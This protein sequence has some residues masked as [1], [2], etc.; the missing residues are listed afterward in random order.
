MA[1][2]YAFQA[3]SI[4]T[5]VLEGGK[6]VDMVGASALVDA[7]ARDDGAD[8]VAAMLAA[9][10]ADPANTG[11]DF[12]FTFT[13]RAG[14]A[15]TFTSEDA[16]AA[17][18]F[19]AA[20]T[21]RFASRFEGLPFVDALVAGAPG[22]PAE[23]LQAAVEPVLGAERSRPPPVPVVTAFAARTAPRTGRVAVALDRRRGKEPID[24]PTR[25]K[26]QAARAVLE[27]DVLARR[28]LG[29]EA[30]AACVFPI[31][32]DADAEDGRR[33]PFDGDLKTVAIVH[34]DGNALGGKII[35]LLG[36]GRDFGKGETLKA[37]S[38][39]VA[40]ATEEAVQQAFA[41]A[42]PAALRPEVTLGDGTRRAMVPARP[43][44]VGGDDVTMILR[45]DVALGW[46]AAFLTAFRA[47]SVTAFGAAAEDLRTRGRTTEAGVLTELFGAGLSAGAGIAYAS[48]SMPFDQLYGLCED[49]AKHAKVQA[50]AVAGEEGAA[51]PPSY[52]S[53][54]RTTASAMEGYGELLGGALRAA[55]GRLLTLNP[56][57]VPTAGDGP[58]RR[59]TVAALE[60]LVALFAD[61][62]FPAGPFR[63]YA[64]LLRT[65]PA[66]ADDTWR[67]L[68]EMARRRGFRAPLAD[69]L[70]ALTAPVG[71]L[72]AL[73][74]GPFA[75]KEAATPLLDALALAAV[76]HRCAAVSSEAAVAQPGERRAS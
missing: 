54:H 73:G 17:R 35:A 63:E 45:A 72:A 58:P 65:D 66:R 34:A 61:P 26:R 13:R 3:K 47:T 40:R 49:L 32:F 64:A 23:A 43:I 57:A 48:A 1:V 7:L 28:C 29:A 33:F 69:V 71:G 46:T 16:E 24:R 39:A 12:G 8:D 36:D 50:K 4:Q 38:A 76:D 30:A 53:F 9:L 42:V 14:G 21:L 44:L 52:L 15:F 27:D 41:E 59:P 6:L 37:M 60:A 5:F 25:L 18:R 68:L 31:D 11:R 2:I 62:K 75:A 20:W 22:E 56:Y 10:A 74:Q 51:V 19:R 67:R 70:E 55:D